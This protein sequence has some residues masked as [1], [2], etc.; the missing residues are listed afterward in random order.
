MSETSGR[1]VRQVHWT[2]SS[3]T[4]DCGCYCGSWLW[5]RKIWRVSDNQRIPAHITPHG[6][7]MQIS[8]KWVAIVN[9]S[10]LCCRQSSLLLSFNCQSRRG[11]RRRTHTPDTPDTFTQQMLG[12]FFF[13]LLQSTL[14]VFKKTEFWFTSTL[15][16]GSGRESSSSSFG[17]GWR[18]R[19]TKIEG[20]L[21]VF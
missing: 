17:E 14:K 3:S 15:R 7:R 16:R 21:L 12:F 4:S 13:F 9:A 6:N 11:D 1:A 10:P 5:C 20:D 19:E 2:A 8:K 18:E